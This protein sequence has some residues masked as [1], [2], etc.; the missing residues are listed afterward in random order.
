MRIA[1]FGLGY[2]GS[3][4][5]A[6]LANSGHRVCGVDVSVE[7]VR[8]INEGVSPVLEKGMNRL[9]KRAVR[10]GL[11]R[12]TTQA[13]EAVRESDLSL[14]CVGTPSRPDG[15]ADLDSVAHAMKE[16]GRSMRASRHYYTV[17]LRSTVPPGTVERL[18]VPLLERASRKKAEKDF[19]ICF[20]PEFLRE[21]SSVQDFFH[22]PKTVIGA[23]GPRSARRLLELWQP[24]KAPIFLTSL[25]VAEMAKYVD[26]AFHALKV[27]FAN[28]IG[29]VSKSLGID[30]HEVMRIFTADRKLNISPLYLRPGFAFGGPC[31]PKDLRAICSAGKLAGLDIPLLSNILPSNAAHL[32]RAR[33]LILSTGKRRIGVLGLVFKSDTDDLRESPA[34]ALVR[35]LRRSGRTVRIFDPRVDTRRLMGTNRAFVEK[36][37]PDLSSLMVG[38]AG[39][40]LRSCDVFVVTGTHPEFEAVAGGMSSE[41]ILIDLVRLKPR[42]VSQHARVEGICW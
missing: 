18:M 42:L 12:A 38:S 21:G 40:M 13:E 9:V 2:V 28:E 36:E 3:V 8:L 20:H 29:S 26:N 16:I 34:C 22:P 10:S 6:C 1:V 5:G 32:E 24:I 30:S 41:Q 17:A 35:T 7:K 19:G 27:A 31:L 33:D 37:L 25:R 39:E 11:L 15:S 4:T 23:A 14:V